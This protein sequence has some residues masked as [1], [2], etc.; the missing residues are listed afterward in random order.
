MKCQTAISKKSRVQK[1]KYRTDNNLA[2]MN[3]RLE[4]QELTAEFP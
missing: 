4:R 3:K 2:Y 1:S